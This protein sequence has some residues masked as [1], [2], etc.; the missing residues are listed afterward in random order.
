MIQELLRLQTVPEFQLILGCNPAVLPTK[1][2]AL[3]Q[4]GATGDD[5]AID[6]VISVAGQITGT[7]TKSQIFVVTAYDEC[8]NTTNAV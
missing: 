3:I 7:C 1:E 6:T 5:C 8:G 4:A 2:M